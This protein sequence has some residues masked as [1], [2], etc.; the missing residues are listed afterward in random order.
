V[1]LDVEISAEFVLGDDSVRDAAVDE[2]TA[3]MF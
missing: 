3:I 1:W 2:A